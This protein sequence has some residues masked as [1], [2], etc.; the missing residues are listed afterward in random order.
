MV[1]LTVFEDYT[2]DFHHFKKLIIEFVPG[3]L[4]ACPVSPAFALPICNCC[5][6]N[7]ISP[8]F[9][10]FSYALSPSPCLQLIPL[11]PSVTT[12]AKAQTNDPAIV[13]SVILRGC[14]PNP[15]HVGVPLCCLPL[16]LPPSLALHLPLLPSCWSPFWLELSLLPAEAQ[17]HTLVLLWSSHFLRCRHP[18]F[19]PS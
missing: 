6:K 3:C 18:S 13:A 12:S 7:L 11:A 9:Q 2:P 5:S 1:A 15:D 14:P 4:P 10:H 8:C 19:P 16:H 17:T